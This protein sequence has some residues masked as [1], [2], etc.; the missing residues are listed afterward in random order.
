MGDIPPVGIVSS[1]GVLSF[2]LTRSATGVHVKRTHRH[3]DGTEL[4]CY[5]SFLS[6]QSFAAWLDSDD[7]RFRYALA[8]QQVRRSFA[9]LFIER[10][11]H[12]HVSA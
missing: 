6:E 7:M 9:Q 4:R 11:D 10:S 2:A 8:F 12:V 3:A 1:D 5:V